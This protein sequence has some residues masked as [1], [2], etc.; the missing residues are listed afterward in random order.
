MGGI[1][2]TDH[3]ITSSDDPSFRLYVREKVAGGE[4]ARAGRAILLVHGSTYASPYF[5]VPVPGYSWMDRLAAWGWAVYA[6]D[7][8]G[9]GRSTRPPEMDAPATDNPPFATAREAA[10]DVADAVSFVCARAGVRQI[11]LLGSSWGAVSAGMFA[12]GHGDRVAKLVYLAPVHACL[13]QGYIDALGDPEDPAQLRHGIGA[14]RRTDETT[15]RNRW[16]EQLTAPGAAAWREESVLKALFRESLLADPGAS[17]LDP[18]AFRAPNGTLADFLHLFAGRPL[19]DASRVRVPALI[20][21]GAEDTDCTHDDASGL[22]YSLSSERKRMV[23]I[24]KGTHYISL[25]RN[26]EPLFCELKLFLDEDIA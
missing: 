1:A 22:F 8:R 20:L 7:V 21:R 10:R 6:L 4:P 19:Y 13:K 11:H 5:D 25:E 15:A 9:Y 14:W 17:D 12:A 26:R 23:T 18:P 24:G 16:D 2:L 3:R